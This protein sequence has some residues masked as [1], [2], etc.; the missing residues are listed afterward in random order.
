V[1]V[2]TYSHNASYESASSTPIRHL[3]LTGVPS[4]AFSHIAAKQSPTSSG[5]AI[6]AAPKH[7]FP[8]TFGLGHPLFRL[9]SSYPYGAAMRVALPKMSGDDPPNCNTVPNVSVG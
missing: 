3:T 7:P 1:I 5:S 6:N 8:A 4:G 9:I 2:S